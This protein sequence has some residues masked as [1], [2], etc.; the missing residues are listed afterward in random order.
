MVRTMKKLAYKIFGLNVVSEIHL[1]ELI[2]L[3]VFEGNVDFSIEVAD[4]FKLWDQMARPEDNYLTKENQFIF[5]I[6]NTAIFSIQQ[7]NKII[8]SPMEGAAEDQIR[9][10]LLGTCMGALLTQRKVLPLHG[11]AVVING[12]AYAFI[13]ESGA[14]KS[15]LASALL[16]KGFQL[17]SDDIIAVSLSEDH[18]PIVTP[19]YPQQKLWQ[20]SLEQ[21][22]ME[23]NQFRP[24]FQRETKYAVP[25]LTNYYPE[26]VPLKGVFELVKT[27]GEDI[28][29][30]TI[31][32]LDRFYMLYRHTY[33]NFL[34]SQLGL[35][36]WHFNL[37]AKIVNQI[38]IFELQR[39]LSGFTANKLS[40]LILNRLTKEELG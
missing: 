28:K 30:R 1:P 40:S 32:G 2:E 19:S 26:K 27:Q 17:I 31:E 35:M 25:V 37:S 8:V 11:S 39:P 5:K 22:G 3:P 15:T 9:L 21:L 36:D 16:S 10:Y 18:D 20:E 4:L 12:G 23:S 13:G 33:R 14:G 34:I 24:I 6:A 38:E 7:G 29:I